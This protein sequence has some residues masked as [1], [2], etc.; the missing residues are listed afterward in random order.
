LIPN[1]DARWNDKEEGE[2]L[3]YLLEMVETEPNFVGRKFSSVPAFAQE[4]A[5]RLR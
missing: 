3:P 5:T 4:G 2:I 1:F